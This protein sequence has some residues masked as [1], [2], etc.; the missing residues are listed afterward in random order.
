ML[1]AFHSACFSSA[2]GEEVARCPTNQM[3]GGGGE[4]Q[5]K[6]QCHLQ[7]STVT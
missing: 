3:I 2:D 6:T 5:E 4:S 7:S 1:T